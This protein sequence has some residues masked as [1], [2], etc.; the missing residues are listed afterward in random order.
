MRWMWHWH[1]RGTGQVLWGP[2]VETSER[3]HL[4]N[5]G[6]DGEIILKMCF[7][8]IGWKLGVD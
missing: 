4:K 6:V 2:D 7:Q 3:V 1:A 8:G 5:L